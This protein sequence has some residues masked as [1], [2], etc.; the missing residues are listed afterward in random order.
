MNLISA[1][2]LRQR[3]GTLNQISLNSIEGDRVT[4]RHPIQ[5]RIGLYLSIALLALASSHLAPFPRAS[6]AIAPA[7]RN[8]IVLVARRNPAENKFVAVGTAFHIGDGWFRTAAHVAANPLPYRYKGRGYDEW[9]LYRADEFGNPGELLSG[10]EVRCVDP[11]WK[12]KGDDYVF[13]HDSALLKAT[14]DSAPPSDLLPISTR[15]LQTGDPISVWGFPQGR[16]LFESKAKV[17][18]VSDIWIRL[19]EQVGTPVLG[20]HSGSPVLDSSGG[21][22]GILVGGLS[23]VGGTGSAVAISDAEAGCPKR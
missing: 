6:A 5:A 3:R 16:V 13:P 4:A 19:V 15:R 10:F 7:L 8:A 21:V 11:R 17:T 14:G 23:G 9:A 22:A 2:E 18:A 1:Q 20:G 12:G